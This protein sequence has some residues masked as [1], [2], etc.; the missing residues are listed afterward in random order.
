MSTPFSRR[1]FLK[2]VAI[3]AMGSGICKG[4]SA[5]EGEPEPCIHEAT[6]NRRLGSP[7]SELVNRWD[8]VVVGSGYGGAVIAA[9]LA[10]GGSLCVLERGKEWTLGSFPDTFSSV[11]GSVRTSRNPLGLFDYCFSPEMDVL[12]GSG[13]G[14]TSLINSNVVI[15]PDRSLFREAEWP[16]ALRREDELNALFGAM[17][18]VK[19][20]LRVKRT[21]PFNLNK[22]R[23][24]RQI[25]E[26]LQNEN[27]KPSYEE[28]DLA[29]NFS[30]INNTQN[31]FGVFQHRCTFCGDCNI[32]CNL[33]AKNT[34]DMNYLPLAV[35]RGAKLFTQVE[36]D[37]LE[38]DPAGGW[39]VHFVT[40]GDN[41][42]EQS[43][44]RI[45]ANT[46][47]L[48]AGS[49]GSTQILLR[50][51]ERRLGNSFSEHLGKH[52]SANGDTVGLNYNLDYQTNSLG[53]GL[54]SSFPA[55]YRV[56]PTI[57]GAA[58]YRPTS[59]PIDRYMIQDGV[60]PSALVSLLKIAVIPLAKKPLDWNKWDRILL[61][62]NGTDIKGALNHSLLYLASGHDSAGGE[63][64]LNSSGNIEVR[65]PEVY[66]EAI[67]KTI[68]DQM[69]Q[70][71]AIS[72]GA[73]VENPG[74]LLGAR[75]HFATVHPL[76]GCRMGESS[77][78]GVV[79]YKGQ[80]FRGEG[81]PPNAVYDD[82]YVADGSIIPRAL[83]VNPLL[84]I[85]ALAERIAWH[86]LQCVKSEPCY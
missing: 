28:L 5:K 75:G 11:L 1:D 35:S 57:T 61:D 50:S 34:L 24:H 40:Y 44:N 72:G 31:E 71:T 45:H 10:G 63:L 19:T 7:L 22:Q 46:V 29:V 36:G 49:L 73:Y 42:T 20:M 85:A 48:C 30:K 82:L 32:G 83:G 38:R 77:G 74:H 62:L 60:F 78:E 9:R 8:T 52:F 6:M 27:P 81:A 65:W 58:D 64:R 4:V 70:H 79:N 23:V 56:G 13:L 12:V 33:R 66:D 37:A 41:G 54:D 51:Q 84:T 14:G 67:F 53:V 3:A 2:S 17:N 21:A 26:M 59:A 55:D 80:V 25:V 47:F 76:G 16:E 15:S 69:K 86:Y 68:A 39:W 43:L 18:V